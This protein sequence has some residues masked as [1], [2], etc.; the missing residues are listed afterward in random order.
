MKVVLLAHTN[1]GAELANLS[2]RTCYSELPPSDIEFDPKLRAMLHAIDSGH[3]SVL[4][5]VSFTFAIEGISR[6]CSHQLVRHRIASV[7]MQSQ[8]YVKM[9]G[10][11]YVT[12]KSIIDSEEEVS[13]GMDIDGNEVTETIRELYDSL[14]GDI[15]YLYEF[16]IDRGIP[17]EDARMVLP[18][19]C[20]TNLVLTM[21]A[22]ELIHF[23][24]LRCCTRAQNE[25]RMLANSMLDI[26]KKVE[27][28]IFEKIGP[29]C[30]TYG[31][32]PE[33]D[34]TCG[35]MKNEKV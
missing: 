23:F 35:R 1:R 28:E 21:N 2:A 22:R 10:F 29:S 31:K 24:S 6:A 7:S 30:V 18:N 32:C 26:C 19:A 12:P 33:G 34:K 3:H 25:I 4:E 13:C 8:R 27:P 5:H 15:A 16:M 11:E 14:M 9:D 17:P 20:C